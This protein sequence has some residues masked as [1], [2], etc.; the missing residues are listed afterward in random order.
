MCP[1]AAKAQAVEVQAD[2][3]LD[4]SDEETPKCA[5]ITHM[6]SLALLTVSGRPKLWTLVS[7]EDEFSGLWADSVLQD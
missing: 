7:A 3:L 5:V 6:L 1:I 4:S 2:L